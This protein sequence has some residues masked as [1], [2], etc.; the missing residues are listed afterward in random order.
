MSEKTTP[1]NT[2]PTAVQTV[3]TAETKRP[4]ILVRTGRAIKNT[5]PKTAVAVVG[6]VILVA[7]AAY[8]GRRSAP[9]SAVII[10]SD[11]E[12][13]PVLSVADPSEDLVAS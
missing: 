7:A 11:Y 2:A 1:Q 8:L 4:N 12:L 9:Y 3:P 5:E 13:E 6:G 10:E